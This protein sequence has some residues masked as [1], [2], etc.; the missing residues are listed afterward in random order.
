[1]TI[2]Q[3][4]K[5]KGSAVISINKDFPILDAVKTMNDKKIGATLVRDE[6]GNICGVL[7]E[8]D[9][10]R[11]LA[12]Y[13]ARLLDMTVADIMTKEIF[14]CTS[15][16]SVE[17]AMSIMTNKRFRHLPVVDDGELVGLISIGDVVKERI[18]ETEHE[19]EALKLY[20]AG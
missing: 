3:I 9:I 19:T 18:A 16:H 12:N 1:M 2:A 13:G 6:K 7:S 14:T 10:V 11:E 20:I 15:N 4:L 17:E 8:R 5:T